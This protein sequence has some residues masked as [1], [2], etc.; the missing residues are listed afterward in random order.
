MLRRSCKFLLAFLLLLAFMFVT[1]EKVFA[2]DTASI[3]VS[4]GRDFYNISISQDGKPD[5]NDMW[6]DDAYVYIRG[7]QNYFSDYAGVKGTL[8]VVSADA[9]RM[10]RKFLMD[11]KVLL[12][13]LQQLFLRLK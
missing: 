3:D 13:Y 10:G 5:Y 12:R 4:Y 2:S 6:S 9:S 8:V 1:H 11:Y 7:N